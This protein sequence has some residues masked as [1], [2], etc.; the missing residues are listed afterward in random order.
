MSRQL[1]SQESFNDSMEVFNLE[2]G[3]HAITCVVPIG[4][5]ALIPHDVIG[6]ITKSVQ[7]SDGVV[8]RIR[9]VTR[10]PG[11]G[12]ISATL[13]EQSV[14]SSEIDGVPTFL[15]GVSVTSDDEIRFEVNCGAAGNNTAD[16][17]SW[18]PTIAYR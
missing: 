8:V 17:V 2:G 11:G 9:K 14:S 13:W 18:L 15:S 16:V 6:Y 3:S 5:N 12:Y 10:P 4:F 1:W 7:G